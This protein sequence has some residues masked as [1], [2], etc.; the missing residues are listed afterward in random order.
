MCREGPYAGRMKAFSWGL[1]LALGA[2][3][4][5]CTVTSTTSGGGDAGGGGDS[6][7][8][9]HDSGSGDVAYDTYR[10][11]S[12]YYDSS[13]SDTGAGDTS[14]PPGDSS[15]SDSSPS[16]SS[17]ADTS[18]TMDTGGGNDTGMCGSYLAICMTSADCCMGNCNPTSLLCCIAGGGNGM[19]GDPCTMDSD[20]CSDNCNMP[21]GAPPLCC[22]LGAIGGLMPGQPCSVDSDCCTDKCD[23][24]A[25]TCQ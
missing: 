18:M 4:F 3:G 23:P 1:L 16:D 9:P 14:T 6:G 22:T 10:Y 12:G 20:C 19:L 25:M 7:T 11:D 21:D 15:S 8:T 5:G 17:S 24:V 13:Y 2:S